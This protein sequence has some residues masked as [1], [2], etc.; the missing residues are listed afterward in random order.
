[1]GHAGDLEP[2]RRTWVELAADGVAVVLSNVLRFSAAEETPFD[3][4]F[5]AFA[6]TV[7]GIPRIRKSVEAG[8]SRRVAEL[9]IEL[10]KATSQIAV[11]SETGPVA[12]IVD[13]VLRLR[14]ASARRGVWGEREPDLCA[15]SDAHP[16][17]QRSRKKRPSPLRHGPI[18]RYAEAAIPVSL[19]TFGATALVTRNVE[20]STPP[21]FAGLPRAARQGR[22][23]FGAHLGV[24]LAKRGVIVFDN[25]ALRRLD[26]VDVVALPQAY[27]EHDPR[28]RRAP[29]PPGA[30]A[31]PLGARLRPR[32]ERD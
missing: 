20:G 29:R 4:D 25:D 5:A 28:R 8:V 23:G 30:R 14:E 27:A 31:E 13:H 7:D 22:N 26:R 11:R 17:E 32:P 21:I 1:M 16:S 3:I 10:M 19:G 18:E 2:E 6:A 15:R 12:S 9:T 24:V